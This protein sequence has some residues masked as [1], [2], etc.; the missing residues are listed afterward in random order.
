[1]EQNSLEVSLREVTQENLKS[2]LNLDVA[3]NQKSFVASNAVSI[4][5]A[6]FEPKAW[7]RAIYAGEQPVGFVMMYIDVE[8]PKY[9]LWRYMIDAAQQGKGYGRKALELV[10]DFVRTQ[11]DARQLFLS[12]VP[13]QDGPGAFY[14]KLGFV[15]TGEWEDDEK[16]MRLDLI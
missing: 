9:Y 2:I 11:P 10:I 12:Y 4:A 3:E 8:R 1:M 13:A 15:D 5:E 7:F 14:Q 16:E 6:H